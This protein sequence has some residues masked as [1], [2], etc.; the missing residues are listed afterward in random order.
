MGIVAGTAV[1]V[2]MMTVGATVIVEVVGMEEEEV[3]AEEEAGMIVGAAVIVAAVIVAAVIVAAVT[4]TGLATMIEATVL[5][6]EMI[7]VATANAHPLLL[8][9]RIAEGLPLLVATRTEE[10]AVRILRMTEARVGTKGTA[11]MMVVVEPSSTIEECPVVVMWTAGPTMIAATDMVATDMVATDMLRRRLLRDTVGEVARLLVCERMMT[12]IVAVEGMTQGHTI[13][14]VVV[15][16]GTVNVIAAEDK[17]GS[18]PTCIDAHTCMH[19]NR[20][21]IGSGTVM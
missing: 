14:I 12:M 20:G 2:R 1:V 4:A 13:V 16:R 3:I 9:T 5:L 17:V 7:A 19:C 6:R 11:V 21:S 10:E 8:P 18:H 15:G